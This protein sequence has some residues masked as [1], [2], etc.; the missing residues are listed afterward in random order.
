MPLSLL[1]LL[2]LWLLFLLASRTFFG[3]F[4]VCN[5]SVAYVVVMIVA[6]VVL[7]ICY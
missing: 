7:D 5:A 4:V 6:T 3:C 2:I 1:L